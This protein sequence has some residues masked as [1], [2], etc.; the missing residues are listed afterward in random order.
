MKD[1]AVAE[2]LD[3][4]ERL[5]VVEAPAGC[6]KTFQGAAHARRVTDTIKRGRVLI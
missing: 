2:L 5:V 6:G 1:N 3:S 4:E